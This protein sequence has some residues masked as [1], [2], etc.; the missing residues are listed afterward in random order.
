MSET[1]PDWDE[2]WS[3]FDE[4]LAVPPADRAAW[5]AERCPSE[6]ARR[7]VEAWLE[8]HEAGSGFLD[9]NAFEAL[10]SDLRD[11]ARR[12][13][14]ETIDGHE[15]VD[16]IGSGSSSVVYKARHRRLDR[17][18]ALKVLRTAL[19]DEAALERFEHETKI[20]ARLRHPSIVPVF[21]AGLVSLGHT[22]TPY[23][24]LDWV[25]GVDLVTH[26]EAHALDVDARIDLVARVCDAAQ[27][28]HEN[29]VVHRDLK[30]AN[31]LVDGD[32]V[33]HLVDFGI[34]RA[35]GAN[36]TRLTSLGH[37]V[38]TPSYMAPEQAAGRLVDRRAD[39]YALGVLAFRLIAD[40]LPLDV[41]TSVADRQLV[42][43]LEGPRPKLRDVRPDV[44]RDL[45]TIV[46]KALAV[47]PD[48]RYATA[49]ALADDLRRHRRGEPILARRPTRV[50]QL[51]TVAQRNRGAFVAA[52]LVVAALVVAT[53][54]STRF[55]WRATEAARRFELV[56]AH[57]EFDS[58]LAGAQGL[59]PATPATLPRMDAWSKRADAFIARR[60]EFVEALDE[61]RAGALP[62]RDADRHIDAQRIAHRA[63]RAEA[64]AQRADRAARLAASL[65]AD[66]PDAPG[67]DSQATIAATLQARAEVERERAAAAVGSRLT[68]RYERPGDRWLDEQL[69]ALIRAVDE[70]TL[71]SSPSQ[72][73][74]LPTR[75][76]VRRAREYAQALEERTVGRHADAWRRACEAVAASPRYGGLRLEPIVGLVPLGPDPRSGLEEFAHLASG[77]PAVRDARTGELQRDEA[78]GIVLVLVPGGEV[79]RGA[80]PSSDEA[81][82]AGVPHVDP[83]ARP[84]EWPPARA[85][86]DPFLLSKY[87]ATQRQW[88]RVEDGRVAR[89]IRDNKFDDERWITGMHPVETVTYAHAAD[90]ARRF[91][92]QVPT[93]AQWEHAARAGT[94]G[95]TWFAAEDGPLSENL[96]DACYGAWVGSRSV[97]PWDDGHDFHAPVGRYAANAF[98]LHDVLGNVREWTRDGYVYHDDYEPEPGTGELYHPTAD[99]VIRGGSYRTECDNARCSRREGASRT[100]IAR[101]DLGVRFSAPVV[102]R[103][104]PRHAR[105]TGLDR[106][107]SR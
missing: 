31:V 41:S 91:G 80:T 105:P 42:E 101:D 88:S 61:L 84:D 30:P 58:I 43:Q 10:A 18:V 103:P 94:T 1:D 14:G 20:L 82:R 100:E 60:G 98:G 63:D 21:D 48:D 97:E 68:W 13:V 59:W 107:R 32:G 106:G 3:I 29:D 19:L 102:A 75:A 69:G 7:S 65:P 66:D 78:T 62:W 44:P 85:T 86:L 56:M 83:A 89:F 17:T 53:V 35:I 5:L 11:H 95:P 6:A 16:V 34:A 46:D 50:E 64:L 22:V 93:E 23:L 77:S 72:S 54:V 2:L 45:A 67:L 15:I 52:A 33:P 92:L 24:V 4:A 9:G 81:A 40:R 104:A 8:A 96:A 76:G 26:C 39:V 51:A 38:G 36:S 25:D 55:A 74:E 73:Y 28:A 37:G 27:Y 49:A 79:V 99:G 70:F 57:D 47:R 71:P 87:E 90:V 12:L